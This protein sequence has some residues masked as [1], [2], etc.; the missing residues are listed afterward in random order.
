MVALSMLIKEE[1]FHLLR[2]QLGVPP[3]GSHAIT[4]TIFFQT[5]NHVRSSLD[6]PRAAC[7]SI[8]AAL[9]SVISR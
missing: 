6:M 7:L 2:S 1:F 4:K 8:Q 3:S 9:P 5:F